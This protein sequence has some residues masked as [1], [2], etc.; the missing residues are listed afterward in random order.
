MKNTAINSVIVR[1][2]A[3]GALA[4]GVLVEGAQAQ[5]TFTDVGSLPGEN[6]SALWSSNCGHAVGDGSAASGAT[7]HAI[8][9]L[10]GG[11]LEDLGDLPGGV[12]Y[13]EAEGISCDG[14][15][16][17]GMSESASGQEAFRWSQ[18]QGM[19]GLGDLPGGQFRSHALAVNDDGAW[20]VGFASDAVGQRPVRW[21]ASGV[22]TILGGLPGGDGS[23]QATDIS[24]DGSVVVG[25]ADTGSDQWPFRWTAAGGTQHLVGSVQGMLAGRA[26]AV[27]ADGEVVVGMAATGT[28]QHAFRY[29][30][31]G[32]MQTLGFLPGG[33][34]AGI[35][36]DCSGDGSV[37]VGSNLFSGTQTFT[38]ATIWDAAHGLRDLQEVLENDYALDLNGFQL[39]V[40]TGISADGMTIVG[41]GVNSHGKTRG[42]VVTLPSD[43]VAPTNYCQS[44][45]NSNG[46][47][48]MIGSQG[49]TS[50]G[51]NDL[52]LTVDGATPNR[53][54][55]FYYGPNQILVPFGDGFR[56]VGGSP[57]RLQAIQT[58]GTGSAS[59]ALDNTSPPQPAGQLES[60]EDWNFQFWY[61]DPNQP[62]GSGF[63]LS[64]ALA[65]TMCP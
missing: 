6:G 55:I 3:I 39:W 33:L 59:F 20:V 30:V 42:W 32:T 50:V 24:A 22:P 21:D 14:S 47:E 37:V 13:S 8:R 56:C 64:N 51:A 49:S 4:V 46:T 25:I 54:G 17:V 52:V 26:Q 1:G 58:D 60:G 16:V 41:H 63:N 27:S 38:K 7:T 36:M 12:N 19:V 5:A 11:G 61:R 2:A 53:F 57:F 28:F 43:C 15:L 10:A 45:P 48:A 18:G 62:G 65:V 40:A 9:R 35:A 29:K 44:S 31:G 23:G 34:F